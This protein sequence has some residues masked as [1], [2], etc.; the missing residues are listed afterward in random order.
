MSVSILPP[1]KSIAELTV[2]E[3]EMLIRRAIQR[4]LQDEL[5][6]LGQEEKGNL[7]PD[8]LLR[9]FGAWNDMRSA[10]EIIVGIYSN[11]TIASHKVSL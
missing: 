5:H 11:R 2:S 6:N 3:L 7:V 9:T 1:D 10:E 4:A 8:S